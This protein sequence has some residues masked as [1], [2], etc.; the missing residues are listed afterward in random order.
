MVSRVRR[1]R[2]LRHLIMGSPRQGP[3]EGKN[4][5]YGSYACRRRMGVQSIDFSLDARTNTMKGCR[6]FRLKSS[7]M[8]AL[9][10][11][12]SIQAPPHRQQCRWLAFL[13][14][15]LVLPSYPPSNV[16]LVSLP[17]LKPPC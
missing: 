16:R 10:P 12:T 6:R 15:P 14:A 7:A 11:M 3:A 4:S 5:R 8:S 1:P 17:V 13:E 9:D 2:V